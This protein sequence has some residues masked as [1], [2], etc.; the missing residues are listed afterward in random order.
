[1]PEIES[2]A[3]K[4]VAPLTHDRCRVPDFSDYRGRDHETSG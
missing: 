1:M 3:R 2:A 4:H